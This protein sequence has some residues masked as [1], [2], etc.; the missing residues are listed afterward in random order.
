MM[1]EP[2][3]QP[4]F[5]LSTTDVVVIVIGIIASIAL[6][7]TAWWIAFVVAFLIAHFFAFCN[8]FRVSRPLELGWSAVFIVLTYSTIAFQKPAWAITIGTSLIATCVVIAIEVR[9]PSYHGIL[10]QRINPKLPQWWAAHSG[11]LD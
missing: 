2:E 9:K 10:W 11:D 6:W 5:R 7:S 3:F 4:G 1:T 8:I